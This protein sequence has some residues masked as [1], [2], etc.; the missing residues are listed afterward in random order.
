MHNEE[1]PNKKRWLLK[2]G[3]A[4]F[5]AFVGYSVWRGFR[6]PPL[7]WTIKYDDGK[8]SRDH[9]DIQTNDAILLNKQ[10]SPLVSK[11]L[12]SELADQTILFRAYAPEPIIRLQAKQGSRLL[13]VVNNVHPEAVWTSKDERQSFEAVSVGGTDH[14]IQV[15][16]GKSE[17]VILQ[18]EFPRKDGFRFAAIGDSGGD[19]ELD[20]CIKRAHELQADFLLHLGDFVYSEGDYALAIQ[21]FHQAA[22]PCYVSIGNHDFHHKGKIFQPYIEE[23]GV[24]SHSFNL[25]G[26]DFIN[27]DSANDFFPPSAGQRGD[28]INSFGKPLASESR[29]VFTHRPLKD[30]RPDDDH[31]INGRGEGE[32]LK[33]RFADIGVSHYFCGHVHHKFE[34][35]LDGLLQLNAGQGLGYEDLLAEQPGSISEI[36]V[37]QKERGL[38][39]SHT[40]KSLNL[41][42]EYYANPVIGRYLRKEN[43]TIDLELFKKHYPNLKV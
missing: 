14:L 26:T 11:A 42:V 23:L 22:L 7:M 39:A 12:M 6:Y 20:W 16:V 8:Y 1:K 38:T 18:A 41:P 40:W 3:V 24:F 31:H 9:L 33:E 25:Q 35:D 2:S 27:L 13:I 36:V 17:E 10:Y 43:P 34:T 4:G 32:W 15:T 19:L 37:V 30:M 29:Y 28:L 21:K 5:A